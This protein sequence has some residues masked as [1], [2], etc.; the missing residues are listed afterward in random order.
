MSRTKRRVLSSST[1]NTAKMDTPIVPGKVT[2]PA[3][4]LLWFILLCGLV[5]TVYSPSMHGQFILDDVS[6]IQN[7]PDMRDWDHI[8]DKLIHRYPASKTLDEMVQARSHNDP[9]RPIV[10]LTFMANYHWGRSHTIG[11]HLVNVLLHCLNVLLFWLLTLDIWQVIFKKRS[12][13]FPCIIATLFAIHPINTSVVSYIFSRS[14]LLATFF[15]LSALLLFIHTFRPEKPRVGYY[16]LSIVCFIISLG[17]K[18]SAA[19]FPVVVLVYDYMLM[20]NYSLVGIRKRKWFHLGLWLV[21]L[22]YLVTRFLYFGKVGDLEAAEPWPMYNYFITQPFSIMKYFQLILVPVGLCLD[23]GIAAARSIFEPAILLSWLGVIGIITAV[24]YAYRR[25][26]QPTATLVVWY[27]VWFFLA[28]APTTSFLPTTAVV[29]EN[30][31]Y[32]AGFAWAGM[33]GLGYYLLWQAT[34]RSMWARRV[35]VAMIVLHI[36]ILCGV[37]FVHNDVFSTG[38]K[39]WLSADQL[40]PRHTRTQ[41]NLGEVYLFDKKDYDKAIYHYEELIDI[42]NKAG[43]LVPK[44]I[45]RNLASMYYW[46]GDRV[47]AEEDYKQ[48][49]ELYPDNLD[50]HENLALVYCDENRLKEAEAEYRICL[51]YDPQFERA[52]Y[53]IGCEC[54][55]TGRLAE[56]AEAFRHALLLNPN[57]LVVR[58]NLAK[59]TAYTQ[60]I[61]NGSHQ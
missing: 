12:Y 48:E 8:W 4:I 15:F 16:A 31:V 32:L 53:V 45:Y 50:A 24:V 1:S 43:R 21:V 17:S 14:D 20:S 18:Q 56:A 9:S 5:F 35:V 47:R 26:A 51:R 39:L 11:Y 10:Y 55:N 54:G 49:L 19:T 59:L 27:A 57:D 33:I 22:V 30:R 28:I 6:K 44:N 34:E 36:G 52:Y 46:R 60:K 42:E 23:H 2:H 41:Q 38:E 3:Y 25:R 13:L 58:Q 40:Y 61:G 7:N 29:V 37:S